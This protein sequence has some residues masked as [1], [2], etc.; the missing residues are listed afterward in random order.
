MYK[1]VNILAHVKWEKNPTY[2]TLDVIRV[3]GVDNISGVWQAGPVVQASDVVGM[4]DLDLVLFG[5][6][7]GHHV[8]WQMELSLGLVEVLLVKS[9]T[10]Y[11]G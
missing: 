5:Q 2:I 9:I 3:S 10:L 6:F 7:K 1:N 4:V 11:P 8:Y